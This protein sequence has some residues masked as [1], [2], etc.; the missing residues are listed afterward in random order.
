[1]KRADKIEF[2]KKSKGQPWH[3]TSILLVFPFFIIQWA[4]ITSRQPARN[5]MV[6]VGM[7]K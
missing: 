4:C 2:H 5:T 1:M 7:L 3:L 6:V